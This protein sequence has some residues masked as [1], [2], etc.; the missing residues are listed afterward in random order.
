MEISLYFW[1]L[2]EEETLIVEGI[3]TFLEKEAEVKINFTSCDLSVLE[4]E[5]KENDF[6]IY[7]GS[8]AFSFNKKKELEEEKYLV[9]SSLNYLTKKEE[10]QEKRIKSLVSLRKIASY[11]KK[12]N[13]KESEVVSLV[14]KQHLKI[15]SDPLFTDIT[16]SPEE[17]QYLIKLKEL[18]NGG[19]II[20]SKGKLS[21]RIEE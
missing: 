7:F 5:D 1:K 21:I 16:I 19:I 11:L 8:M 15:G 9:L 18:L 10:N 17:I 2:K 13:K 4:W 20:L 14:E 3:K 12:K 6:D